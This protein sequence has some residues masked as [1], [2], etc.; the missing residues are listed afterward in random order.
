[1]TRLVRRI[2]L[3]G[4]IAAFEET[5]T[6]LSGWDRPVGWCEHVSLGPPFL[7]RGVTLFDASLTRGYSDDSP[8]EVTWPEGLAGGAKVDLSR[9]REP[10]GPDLVNHYLVDPTREYGFFTALNPKMALLFGYV[11][12]RRDFGWLNAWESI[13]S[14][15]TTRGMEFSDTPVHATMRGLFR[16]PEV[17]STPAFDWLDGKG[18]LVKKFWAFITRVPAGFRGVADVRWS[19]DELEIV[20]RETGRT[21]ALGPAPAIR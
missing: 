9:V 4:R 18:K 19:G 21:I 12:P 16:K 8:V 3:S 17:F 2:S 10:G 15:D 20:E 11:F 1:M 5:A 13:S 7:D 14:G 6:N